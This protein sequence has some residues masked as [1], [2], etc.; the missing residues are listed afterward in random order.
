LPLFFLD[1]KKEKKRYKK[2]QFQQGKAQKNPHKADGI[3]FN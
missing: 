1:S 3:Y 2:V